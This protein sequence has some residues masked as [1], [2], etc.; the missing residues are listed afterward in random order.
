M[1]VCELLQFVLSVQ[2]GAV[3]FV[4]YTFD[5]TIFIIK[6][7][8]EN[9]KRQVLAYLSANTTEPSPCVHSNGLAQTVLFC[10][11]TN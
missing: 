9:K 1:I 11:G 3:Q 5:F 6:I 2:I 4:L 10:V 7:Q 8:E